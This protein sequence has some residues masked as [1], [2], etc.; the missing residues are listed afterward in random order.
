MRRAHRVSVAKNA[1]LR[2]SEI[3]ADADRAGKKIA[4]SG[5]L[6]AMVEG[7]TA[8][9]VN[10]VCLEFYEEL[11]RELMRDGLSRDLAAEVVSR[12]ILSVEDELAEI[13]AAIHGSNGR[14]Q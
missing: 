13:N 11:L 8:T 6:R 5:I 7:V 9:V 2:F 4:R 14:V 1:P 3:L 12:V 10:E